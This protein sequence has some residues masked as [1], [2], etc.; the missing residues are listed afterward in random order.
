V[1]LFIALAAVTCLVTLGGDLSVKVL[2]ILVALEI[3]AF[4]VPA[5]R[6]SST[7]AERRATR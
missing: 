2:G 6:S 5:S 3:V 4:V 7:G 1:I